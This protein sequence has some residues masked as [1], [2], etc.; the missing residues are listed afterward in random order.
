MARAFLVIFALVCGTFAWTAELRAQG[1]AI[2]CELL[3]TCLQDELQGIEE[4]RDLVTVRRFVT[5]A[6]LYDLCTGSEVEQ[7]ICRFYIAGVH[8]TAEVGFWQNGQEA[9][10]CPLD[11]FAASELQEVVLDYLDRHPEVDPMPAAY[12]V[13]QAF[14]EGL[15]CGSGGN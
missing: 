15:I 10:W 14:S 7:S 9:P 4:P 12:A 6:S 5:A 11:G 8:D 1:P 2:P 13:A 3:D